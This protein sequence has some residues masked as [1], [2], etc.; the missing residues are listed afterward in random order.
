MSNSTV[1]EVVV[2]DQRG[3]IAI[4]T[5]LG[6][7]LFSVPL[8]TAS[9]NLAQNT[10]IDAR[11]KTIIMQRQYCGLAVNEYLTY[12]LADTAR[13]DV[14]LATNVDPGDPTGATHTETTD[15]CGK[16]I[17]I[18]VIQQAV[19]P[20][21]DVDDSLDSLVTI[22]ALAAYNK[23]ALQ[24]TKT[25]SD[26]NPTGGDSVTYTITV[27]NRDD[28]Q[29]DLRNI[30]ETLPDGFS[31]DCS[32]PADQLTLP[33]ATPADIVPKGGCPDPD[34][35][36]IEWNIPGN[37]DLQPG[38]SATL[39]FTAV[40]GLTFGSYCNE[41][42]AKPDE[43]DNTSGKTAIV[44]I[45]PTPGLCS[46]EALVGTKTWTAANLVSTNTNTSPYS[47]T[48]EVEFEI[49]LENIGTEDLDLAEL[50]DLLPTG[51][52]FVSTSTSGDIIDAPSSIQFE[53]LVDREKIIWRFTPDV[54]LASDTTQMLKYTTLAVI[55]RGNHRSDLI[56]DFAGGT[57]TRD[58]YT[59]PTA[60][61]GVRDVFTVSATSD[62]D[63]KV[64]V[65]QHVLVANQSGIV[66]FWD[67]K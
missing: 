22:P 37:P 21:A 10:A 47:Y 46:G 51:F 42:A 41:V 62:D 5:A 20:P 15:L 24:V 8:I 7:L 63:G 66:D 25:V 36:D 56:M 43:N 16:D 57:F 17:T 3:G 60:M 33:G 12:L 64:V 50:I 30:K 13:W 23:R 34:D 40:T 55:S 53:T 2:R 18:T 67:L 61:L 59:W 27:A 1:N 14:W 4:L 28:A 54:T 45:G 31:Y 9:L 39:T 52:S 49:K 48:F 38:E 11:V 65:T 35:T 32:G 29:A 44:Q 19:L 26:S 6:F 58:K